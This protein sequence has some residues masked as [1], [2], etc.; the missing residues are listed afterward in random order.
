M[1]EWV[2][3]VL[4][5]SIF[6]WR[7]V[8]PGMKLGAGGGTPTAAPAA[9][10]GGATTTTAPPPKGARKWFEE[11]WPSILIVVVGVAAVYWGFQ[12]TQ[13]RPTDAGS[14]SQ[15][16]WLSLLILWGMG[17]ALIALNAKAW[18]AAVASTLHWV[19]A[20][21]MLLLFIVLPFIGWVGGSSEPKRAESAIR[22][23]PATVVPLASTSPSS[24]PKLVIPARGRSELVPIPLNMR[25]VMDGDQFDL[26]TVYTDGRD[27]S[28]KESGI[29][30]LGAYVGSYA[31][32]KASETNV[33]SYAFAPIN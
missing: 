33:V 31:V 24:W 8:L 9:V 27:C 5:V 7:I 4:L 30:P 12:N 29:C 16:H 28:F 3:V 18:G 1:I 14:W 11:N 25:I 6:V 21:V 20:S 10:G 23:M 19:L 2:V 13:I 32:N 17:H 15:N 26:H 22:S